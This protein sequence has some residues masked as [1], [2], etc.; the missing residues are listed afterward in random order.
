[1][2]L[3]SPSPAPAIW[4]LL[5]KPARIWPIPS[6]PRWEPYTLTGG[7]SYFSDPQWT[8]YPV[9]FYRLSGL[10]FAGRPGRALEPAGADRP[11]L[12]VRTNRFGFTI[13]GTADIPVVVEA[14][15]NLASPDGVRSKAAP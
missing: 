4:A 1:M 6:G 14:C 12:G 2:G 7:A 3:G 15:T 10:T 11:S 5:C 8:N 13:T 9:R